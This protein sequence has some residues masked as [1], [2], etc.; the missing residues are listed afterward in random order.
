MTVTF[1]GAP[2]R[3]APKRRCRDV[4]APRSP[5]AETVSAETVAP[6][7]WR[8]N[9]GAEMSRTEYNYDTN[10]ETCFLNYH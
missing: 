10:Q 8:R 7:R 6:K 9:G 5:S 3:P 4:P 2:K 1:Q